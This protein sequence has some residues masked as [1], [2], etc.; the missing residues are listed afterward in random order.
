MKKITL[1]LATACLLALGACEKDLNQTPIS[2]GSVPD[3]YK[4]PQDFEQALTAVYSQLRGYPNR[5]L[6]LSELRSDNIYAASSQGVRDWDPINNFA[7]ALSSSA[8]M[9]D[10]WATPFN[11]IFRANVFLDQLGKNG[12][13]VGETL[14]KRYEAEARFLRAFH[15]FELVRTFGKVP[16]IDKPMI[17]Q[18]VAQI[19]RSPVA[20]VYTLIM[21]DLTFAK[22]NLALNYTGTSVG[23]VTSGAAKGLLALVHLTRS[24]PTYG[25]EGPGLGLNEF[26]Q[27]YDLLREVETSGRYTFAR[28]TGTAT[29]AYANIF[30]YTNENNPEVV[31]D[32]QYIVG[33][34]ATFPGIF[35]PDAYF[36]SL[37]IPFGSRGIEIKP[38]STN[39]YNSYPTT[40][41]RRAFNIQLGYTQAGVTDNRP[42]LKKWISA[43][44]RGT[45]D[46]DWPINFIVMRYTDILL[47]KAEAILRGG[48]GTPAEALTIVNDVRTRAGI[49]TLT[50]L[51][52]DQ[53]LEERRRE[54]L[55][56]GLR[57]HDLVRTGKVLDVMNAWLPTEDTR[58]AMPESIGPNHIIYALPQNELSATPG[59]Y[60]QNP[61]Y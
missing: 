30:S 56:E 61:G 58:N 9:T 52:L 53:L 40:D 47:M 45:G 43:A 29:T 34:G 46:S 14:R 41:V 39:M 48:V 15:Y 3:F 17:P 22:D 36:T 55:G 26:R 20:D 2:N 57:W 38:V 21:S 12:T 11:A 27:A 44:G 37:G 31:L 19:P 35:V 25:I 13:V 50:S 33:L 60:E 32:V 59:L 1:L 16:I 10:S 7:T 54:F 18:E 6:F 42:L 5:Q 49:P 23:R 51:T 28:N 24:G 4:T 8:Y